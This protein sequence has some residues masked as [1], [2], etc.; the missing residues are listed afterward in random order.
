MISEPGRYYVTS[1]F[2]SVAYLHGKKTLVEGGRKKHMYYVN[3][4]VYGSFLDERMGIK[5]RLPRALNQVSKQSILS[6]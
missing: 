1:A 6:R 2:K 5:C 4:G 3:D